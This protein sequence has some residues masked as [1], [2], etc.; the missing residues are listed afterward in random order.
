MGLWREGVLW[1]LTATFGA[2]HRQGGGPC[3]SQ[4]AGLDLLR[5]ALRGVSHLTQ[6]VLQHGQ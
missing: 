4:G 6:G 1:A 5:L 2:I 3:Q